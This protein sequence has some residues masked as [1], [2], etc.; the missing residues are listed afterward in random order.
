[1]AY[2]TLIVDTQNNVKLIRLNRPEALN[3]LN[4]EL[5]SELV[6]VLMAAD[7]DPKVRAIVITGSDKAF[8]A[9]ADVK[10]M[11]EKTF[12]D[13]ALTDFFGAEGNAIAATRAVGA[14]LR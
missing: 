13:M 9:G 12:A 10:E 8:A 11:S 3:A 5:L 14:N 7:A 6:M 1:M 4:S 2:K